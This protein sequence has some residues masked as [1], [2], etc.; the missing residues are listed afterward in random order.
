[1]GFLEN[2]GYTVLGGGL[3]AIFGFW[4]QWVYARRERRNDVKK[5]Q[6]LLKPEFEAL[7]PA[8][9]Y[10]REVNKNARQ[11]SKKNFKS[12]TECEKSILGYLAS[13]G[14][15]YLEVRVWD[16]IISSGNL[17]KLNRVEIGIIHALQQGIRHYEKTMV[18]LEEEMKQDMEIKLSGK[19]HPN[20]PNYANVRVLDFYLDSCDQVLDRTMERFKALD[21]LSWFDYDGLIAKHPTTR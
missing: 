20:I 16:T 2:V 10:Q 18:R 1:M 7:Y 12:V 6:D 14:R 21:R 4:S 15:F 3:A 17:I 9:M 19:A 13:V 8:L 11:I 5:I